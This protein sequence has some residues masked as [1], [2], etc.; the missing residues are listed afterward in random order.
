M[1][2]NITNL[3]GDNI[4]QGAIKSDRMTDATT[5]VAGVV[6]LNNTYPPVGT[7]TTMATINVV[8]QVY[9]AAVAVIPAGAQMLFCQ[10][11]HAKLVGPKTRMRVMSIT[12][13]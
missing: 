2:D 13:H 7:A 5:S 11:Q 6:Q 1:S 4:T 3:D 10:A 8:T 9:N 12:K